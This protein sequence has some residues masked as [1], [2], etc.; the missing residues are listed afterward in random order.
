MKN[1]FPRLV[2]FVLAMLT[3]S[4]AVGV[5]SAFAHGGR[6]GGPGGAKAADL[7]DQAAKQLGVTT[8]RLRTAIVDAAI[9]RIDEAVED[10]DVEA[11]DSGEL[12][13]EA[14]ESLRYAMRIS[15]TRV[16]A[17]NLD[18][19]TQRLN[20]AFRAAR[21]AL[22]TARID[23]AVEEGDLDA[24]EAA[25]LKEELADASLPGYKAA[26]GLGIRGYGH[27]GFGCRS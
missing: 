16:V 4:F 20:T 1:R 13:E 11:E 9:A 15:R 2:L 23:E 19:T 6:G 21:K 18:I 24:E 8:A 22:I 5:T 27:G 3:A 25:Q 7:A 17:A 12:K 26:G 10:G 14:R